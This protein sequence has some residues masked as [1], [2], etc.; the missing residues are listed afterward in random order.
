MDANF[1][2]GVEKSVI[3]E[4][5]QSNADKLIVIQYLHNWEDGRESVL[6]GATTRHCKF[7]ASLYVFFFS[8]RRK[9]VSALL[10]TYSVRSK[11]LVPRLS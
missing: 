5:I 4:Y 11:C 9:L 8:N 6:G 10:I 3:M 7:E 1:K 2:A